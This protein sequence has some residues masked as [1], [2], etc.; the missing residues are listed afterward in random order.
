MKQNFLKNV[1]HISLNKMCYAGT[2]CSRHQ[3]AR[4]QV[5][6]EE[7]LVEITRSLSFQYRH[8]IVSIRLKGMETTLENIVSNI[9]RVSG[10]QGDLNE[11]ELKFVLPRFLQL[12]N[13]NKGHKF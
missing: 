3:Q 11:L 8:L 9:R 6:C 13:K 4:D 12:V 5:P 1:T 7:K 10:V 2:R